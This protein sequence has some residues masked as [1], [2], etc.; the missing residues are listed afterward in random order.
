MISRERVAA[1]LRHE[2]TDRIPVFMWFHPETAERLR[3]HLGI[4]AP[5]VAR[6]MGN[7]VR[8]TWI[9]NNAA[10]EGV[11]HELDGQTHTDPWGITWVKEG[12]F[13]QILRSPLTHAD[14]RTCRAY[15]MPHHAIPSLLE[16]MSALL[17]SVRD[18]FIGCD[19]SPCLFELLCRLRGMDRAAEDL[20][21]DPE[22]AELLL[23]RAADFAVELS[24]KACARFPLDWFWTGDDVAGQESM[25]MSPAVWRA[26]IKPRLA[27]IVEVGSRHGLPVAY[28][29]CGAVRPIIPDLIEIGITVL[30]PVQ[31]TSRGMDPAE[32]K[33][34]FGEH[35]SFMGGVDTV[36]LLPQGTPEEVFR[37]TAELI[38]TLGAGGGYIL[39]ASHTVPPETPL[40]NIFAMYRAAG[41]T[42]EEI[43]AR[44]HTI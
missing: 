34:E 15:T 24:E 35:L 10:M 22:T 11:V 31:T 4:P 12:P 6:V 3:A 40:E 43:R 7:D 20:A 33:R 1:A 21:A 41:I 39:S 13:N 37:E 27:R 28:H 14:E 42:E 44:A 2:P 16:H 25:I 5:D 26:R 30:N 23:D 38:G 36:E 29:C 18:E 17:P 8:Q 19:V 32:L 9:G